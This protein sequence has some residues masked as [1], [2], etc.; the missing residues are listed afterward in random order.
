MPSMRWARSVDH[1]ER[2]DGL[3]CVRVSR[4]GDNRDDIRKDPQAINTMV[5]SYLVVDGFED[6]GQCT[7]LAACTWFE[8]L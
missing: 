1:G 2:V 6:R 5:Q 3:H 7:G 4:L 8:E